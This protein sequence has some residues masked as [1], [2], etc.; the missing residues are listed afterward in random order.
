MTGWLAD[1]LPDRL[2][3]FATGAV[4]LDLQADG[5]LASPTTIPS[6]VINPGMLS[7]GTSYAFQLTVTDAA[8]GASAFAR[9]V[10]STNRPPIGGSVEVHGTASNFRYDHRH[11]LITS[12]FPWTDSAIAMLVVALI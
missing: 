10:V 5:V 2:P 11:E 4:A 9:V 6:L 8:T 3:G 12:L 1:Y 7:G